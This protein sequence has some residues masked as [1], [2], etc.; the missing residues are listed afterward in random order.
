MAFVKVLKPF[1]NSR[2]L[3]D[4]SP[5]PEIEILWFSRP[6]QI[7]PARRQIRNLTRTSGVQEVLGSN[8]SAPTS[9]WT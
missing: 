1:D 4:S 2:K 7:R 5:R 8:P 9:L 6:S 3:P